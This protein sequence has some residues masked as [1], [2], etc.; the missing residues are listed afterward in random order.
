[1]RIKRQTALKIK[2]RQSF[3]ILRFMKNLQMLTITLNTLQQAVR[4]MR[5]SV[6][7]LQR[8]LRQ[9]ADIIFRMQLKLKQEKMF[10]QSRIIPMMPK[11]E[12]LL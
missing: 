11:P 9:T 12:I 10:L 7:I 1:M 5:Q 4:I 8:S 6:Q 2:A 3:Q